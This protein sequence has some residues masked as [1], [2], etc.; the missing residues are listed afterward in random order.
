MQNI[1]LSTPLHALLTELS[2]DDHFTKM[3]LTAVVIST[4]T[5]ITI[6]VKEKKPLQT[7]ES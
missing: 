2:Q 6:K 7:T 4:T 5:E 3:K 1:C